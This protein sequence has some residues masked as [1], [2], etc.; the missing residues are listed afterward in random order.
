MEQLKLVI[1]LLALAKLT[2]PAEAQVY[3]RE[4]LTKVEAVHIVV[5]DQS[6]DGCLPAP[7]ELQSEAQ[8]LIREA[9]IGISDSASGGAYLLEILPTAAAVTKLPDTCYGNLQIKLTR[10]EVLAD[11]TTGLVI[12][13]HDGRVGAAP[14]ADFQARFRAAIGAMIKALVAEIH[15]AHSL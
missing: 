5:F 6:R 8:S 1:A 11:R 13:A 7:L 10:P 4:Q 2:Q 14:Q 15:D 3:D 12:A 9:G